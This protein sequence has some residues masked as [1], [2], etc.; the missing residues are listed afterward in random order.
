MINIGS[1]LGV[2]KTSTTFLKDNNSTKTITAEY[3]EKSSKIMIGVAMLS[4]LGVTL[5]GVGSA[6]FSKNGSISKPQGG[7][8]N[9]PPKKRRNGSWD[10]QWTKGNIIKIK[11]RNKLKRKRNET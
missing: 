3:S 5:L 11:R 8:N 7:G 1:L 4:I 6:L 2:Q 9:R 10:Q